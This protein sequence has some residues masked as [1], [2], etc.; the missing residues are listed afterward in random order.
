MKIKNNIF[1]T[2]ISFIKALH[3][4]WF[5]VEILSKGHISSTDIKLKFSRQSG[6]SLKETKVTENIQENFQVID[7]L[8]NR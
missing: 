2:E 1:I 6:I 8:N 5:L 4:N 3:F 7:I